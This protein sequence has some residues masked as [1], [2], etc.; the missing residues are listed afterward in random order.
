MAKD[1][2]AWH[3]LDLNFYRDE[4]VLEAGW[5]AA[6]LY[7]AGLAYLYGT[8]S[9]DGRMTRKV[10]PNLGVSRWE[11][12][13]TRLVKAGLWGEPDPDSFTVPAYVKWC[14]ESDSARRTREWR[15]RQASQRDVT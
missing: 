12:L 4:K 10:I 15:E 9:T 1:R 2:R 13:A 3:P 6:R 5:P 7:L 14:A 11:Q 8:A